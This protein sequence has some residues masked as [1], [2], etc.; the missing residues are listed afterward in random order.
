MDP[1][2]DKD[3]STYIPIDTGYPGYYQDPSIFTV[4]GNISSRRSSDSGIVPD[5]VY[6]IDQI[7]C[8]PNMKYVATTF[9]YGYEIPCE[10]SGAEQQYGG[11]PK[12]IAYNE[13]DGKISKVSLWSVTETKRLVKVF[14]IM[15]HKINEPKPKLWAVSD[16]KYFIFK[17]TYFYYN[18][19]IFDAKGESKDLFFPNHHNLVNSLAFIKSGDLV[20]ALTEPTHNIYIFHQRHNEWNLSTKFELSYFCD[21][22]ITV[23]GKLILFDD[24]IFQLTNWDISTLTVQTNCVIDWCYK[25]W[26]VEVDQSGELFPVYAVY[27]QDETPKKS[28]LYIYSL[29]SGINMALHPFIINSDKKSDNIIGVINDN[30]DIYELLELFQTEWIT[31]LR[32]ELGDYNRIFVLS[33][34]EYI[35]KMIN[36]ELVTGEYF[37]DPEISPEI[38]EKPTF[39]GRF[40]EWRLY[41]KNIIYLE[42]KIYEVKDL[43]KSLEQKSEIQIEEIAEIKNLITNLTNRL[44][45]KDI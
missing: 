35:K 21:G 44:A 31:Y 18:F 25:V 37:T 27:L 28:K 38:D 45:K 43:T 10:K 11:D 4:P 34:T 30:L 19:E 40:L 14:E 12:D 33:D 2:Y 6:A 3:D 23:E 1:I 36:D 22:F 42:E 26:H 16:D 8:S 29:K 9:K 15:G 39:T 5:N 32:K 41:Y 17:T 24:Q 7:V 20:V 13:E